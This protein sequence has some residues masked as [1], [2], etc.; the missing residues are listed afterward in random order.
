MTLYILKRLLLAGVTLAAILFVSYCLL[1]LAPGDPTRSNLFGGEAAEMQIDAEKGGLSVNRSL[2]EKLNLDKPTMWSAVK[3]RNP[4][5]SAF[6]S[7]SGKWSA[8]VIS[9]SRLLL[10]PDVRCLN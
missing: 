4:L 5:Q 9:V 7:G 3:S 1:R 2:R 10:I 6:F 8:M